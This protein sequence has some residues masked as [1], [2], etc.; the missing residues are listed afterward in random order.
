[1]PNFN[2]ATRPVFGAG[3]EPNP[4]I[5]VGDGFLMRHGYV[6]VSCGWQCDV[7]EISGLFRLHAPEALEGG[8]PIRGRIY[9]NL[10]SPEA[11]PHF[12]LSDRGH[13]AHPAAD[14]DER[15][16]VLLVRDQ[17]DGPARTVPGPKTGPTA[18]TRMQLR[19]EVRCSTDHDPSASGMID[20]RHHESRRPPSR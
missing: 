1:M 13:L 9:V 20:H 5:D 3:A 19:G 17:L 14:L 2:H 8:R 11:V 10:Q 6:V 15:D 18:Q 7:P 16:A 4:A 12:L